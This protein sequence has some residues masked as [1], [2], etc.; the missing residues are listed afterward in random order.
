M[1]IQFLRVEGWVPIIWFNPDTYVCLTQGGTWISNVICRGLINV[2]IKD[3]GAL[4][5]DRHYLNFL[6]VI[7]LIYYTLLF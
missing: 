4:L 6:F 3:D 7:K 1:E 5:V 2:Q